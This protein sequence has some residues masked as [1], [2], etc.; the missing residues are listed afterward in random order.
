MKQ[1]IAFNNKLFLEFSNFKKLFI[2]NK[3]NNNAKLSV[4][5][6]IAEDLKYGDKNTKSDNKNKWSKLAWEN[7]FFKDE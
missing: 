2:D 4:V 1:K 3:K 5:N 6:Q 7:F